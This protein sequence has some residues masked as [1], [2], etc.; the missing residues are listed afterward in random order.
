M[1]ADGEV[2]ER[3]LRVLH[4][5]V[6]ALGAARGPR[7]TQARQR[8]QGGGA[9]PLVAAD[10][11]TDADRRALGELLVAQAGGLEVALAAALEERQLGALPVALRAALP[12]GRAGHD[13]AAALGQ[14]RCFDRLV[15]AGGQLR[16]VVDENLERGEVGGSGRLRD[17]ARAHPGREV[18]EGRALAVDERGERAQRAA[19]GRLEQ[20]D[21]RSELDEQPPGEGGGRRLSE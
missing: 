9:A 2:V 16:A 17:R 19:R 15:P 6:D 10:V 12:V 1:A 18:G 20:L 13:G 4:G 5:E 11:A 21:G 14:R 7:G 3:E 8:R